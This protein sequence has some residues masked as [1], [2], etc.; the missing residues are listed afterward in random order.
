MSFINPGATTALKALYRGNLL[1]YS[2]AIGGLND[3]KENYSNGAFT[4]NFKDEFGF[5]LHSV[6]IPRNEMVGIVSDDAESIIDHN[7]RFEEQLLTLK[8]KYFIK[9]PARGRFKN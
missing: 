6:E 1:Y 9:C 7:H 3:M 2:L 8:Q 4:I 5:I